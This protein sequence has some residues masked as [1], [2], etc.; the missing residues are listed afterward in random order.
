ML[1]CAHDQPAAERLIEWMTE[2]SLL[3]SE[4][5]GKDGG[6]HVADGHDSEAPPPLAAPAW[7]QH[8]RHW[9]EG[10]EEEKEA[11]EEQVAQITDS[12]LLAFVRKG[13][14]FKRENEHA[15]AS[16]AERADGRETAREVNRHLADVVTCA[17][18]TAAA[19]VTH[20]EIA[21]RNSCFV[22]SV[23]A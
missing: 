15:K 20:I 22:S 5:G 2:K 3:L 11:T 19:Q 13:G 12:E 1:S 8:C 4:N 9:D 18:S 7:L 23:L 10:Y 21:R 14:S 6:A 17:A 16:G